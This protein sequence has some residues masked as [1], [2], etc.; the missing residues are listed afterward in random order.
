MPQP[1]EFCREDF[2]GLKDV[3]SPQDYEESEYTYDYDDH[4]DDE[5]D[6]FESFN[7][8]VTIVSDSAYPIKNVEK[9][10]KIDYFS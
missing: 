10:Q 5:Y 1:P 3:F 9:R 6:N 2:A 7:E 4:E 8:M